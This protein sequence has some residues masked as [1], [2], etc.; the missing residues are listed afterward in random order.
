MDDEE[1]VRAH[2]EEPTYFRPAH[3]IN[4][5]SGY[6]QDSVV[7]GESEDAAW[8]AAAEF[9]RERL[10]QI[11]QIKQEMSLLGGMV[12]LL[13]VEPGDETAP[14]YQRTIAR[15]EAALADLKRG[16]K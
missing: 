4:V 12:V 6:T 8:S 3:V 2:W 16:M 9:T 5:S 7:S 1:F 14:I 15:L 10:E 13:S 11:R